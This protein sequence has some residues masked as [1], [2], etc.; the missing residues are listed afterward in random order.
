MHTDGSILTKNCLDI[1]SDNIKSIFVQVAKGGLEFLTANT[2]LIFHKSCKISTQFL[3]TKYTVSRVDFYTILKYQLNILTAKY[4]LNVNTYTWGLAKPIDNY[5]GAVAI[6]R[7]I[8]VWPISIG[9]RC[10]LQKFYSCCLSI[11]CWG[12]CSCASFKLVSLGM[13][14]PNSRDWHEKWQGC[15]LSL[16]WTGLEY[17]TGLLHWDIFLF[18]TN[19]WVYF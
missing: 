2:E 7:W 13:L 18:W 17:W 3:T 14:V 11:L 4:Q 5:N 19:F 8:N 16:D 10:L 6:A 1:F 15:M 9:T 12:N